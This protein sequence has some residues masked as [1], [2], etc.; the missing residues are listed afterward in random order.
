[1]RQRLFLLAVACALGCAVPVDAPNGEPRA[2]A[3]GGKAD[4]WGSD[5]RIETIDG[6]AAMRTL[7]RSSAMLTRSATL[8]EV[9][10]DGGAL[11]GYRMSPWVESLR[12]TRSLCEDVRFAEQ[13]AMGFCSATLVAPD[14]VLTAGHCLG[15]VGVSTERA[16]CADIS[17]LFDFTSGTEFFSPESVYSCASVESIRNEDIPNN[18][19]W[20]LIRLDRAV[21]GRNVAPILRGTPAPGTPVMQIAHPTGI[22]Q[23]LAPGVVTD[24]AT[25]DE[26]PFHANVSFSYSADIFGGTSGGSVYAVQELALAGLPAA[27][28]GQDYVPNATGTCSV[29]GVCGVNT[30]CETPPLAFATSTLVR[31]LEV[32]SPSLLD[33]MIVV[34][35]AGPLASSCRYTCA[36]HN[37]AEGQCAND[38]QCLDGCLTNNFCTESIEPVRV[39]ERPCEN[40]WFVEGQCYGEWQCTRGCL[41][42]VSS[43]D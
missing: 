40:Y 33:E 7:A 24:R 37:Y 2:P 16:R 43:C 32:E 34:G 10:D 8:D 9:R 36:D 42:P 18:L 22:P 12:I 41:E 4:V 19:D 39:C 28:S 11:S 17:V 29:V 1:M 38:W 15:G 20:A 14:L 6:V 31:Y 5:D 13:P 23:K 21:R 25:F 30:T 26:N 35:D 3:V 27:F